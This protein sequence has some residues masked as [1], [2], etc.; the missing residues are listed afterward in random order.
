MKLALKPEVNFRHFLL[1]VSNKASTW[2]DM[3]RIIISHLHEDVFGLLSSA[4][5]SLE[6]QM[7]VSK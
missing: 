7:L 1:G 4:L 5:L 2:L 6:T 3:D